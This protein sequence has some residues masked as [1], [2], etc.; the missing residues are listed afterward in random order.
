M[1]IDITSVYL[2]PC[3]SADNVYKTYPVVEDGSVVI[4]LFNLG[5]INIK[6]NVLEDKSVK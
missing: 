4:F 3:R 1:P 5:H 6:A 2:P